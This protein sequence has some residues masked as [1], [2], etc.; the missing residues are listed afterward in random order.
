MTMNKLIIEANE[1]LQYGKFEYSFCGGYAIDLFLEYESRT[2]GD[3][4]ICAYWSDRDRIIEYMQSQGYK[5]Y[6]M[7]GG[8]R[9]HHIS[10]VI[11][12][13]RIKRNIFCIK[14]NCRLV[15]IYPLDE[16]DCC[17]IEFFD[18][19]Q[20]ELDFIEFLFN[21]KT[22]KCFLYARC[23]DITRDLQKAVLF[24][25]EIPFLSPEL[26]LLY[27]ST[28]T[29]RAGYQQD[30]ELSYGK[31]DNEQKEWL[32]NALKKAYPNGHRWIV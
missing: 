4:D 18:I 16:E 13:F 9:A 23:K 32:K 2:H 29:E 21:D 12:Q 24:S 3:V 30:F 7:L 27:K 6:E 5:I 11:N 22:E 1:L 20:T 10:D 15:K 19:G 28:D 8:G 26:C 17:T 25:G 14:E 31:M